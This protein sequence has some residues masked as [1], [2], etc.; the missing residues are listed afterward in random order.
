MIKVNIFTVK[1]TLNSQ[2]LNFPLLVN[3]KLLKEMGIEI[4]F[5]FTV[6]DNYPEGD[7]F[8]VNSKIFL[9]W[10]KDRKEEIFSFFEKIRRKTNRLLWF[11]NTD[12]TGATQFAVLPYVDGYYKGQILKEKENYLKKYYGKRIYTDFYHKKYNII[13]KEDNSGTV[14]PD[15]K[16]LHKIKVYWN[17]SLGDYSSYVNYLY[18]LRCIS[19]LFYF[20]TAEFISS[21]KN[22][23]TDVSCRIGLKYIRNTIKFHRLRIN[24]IL[25]ENFQV[26]TDKI[27]LKEYYSE[28]S[29][30]RI[31]ISPFGAGEFAYRDFEIIINGAMLMKPDMSHL[32]TWPNLY[33]EYKTYV[34]FKWDFSDL[35]DKI[36]EYLAT[37]KYSTIAEEAQNIYHKYLYE[38]QGKEEFCQRFKKIV[39]QNT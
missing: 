26:S 29:N 14:I 36:K 10:W 6:T 2:A 19:N 39:T 34:P 33:Q 38:K 18:R 35:V 23:K 7:T 12:S 16:D 24:E 8:I 22:R 20:R 1:D 30:S 25:K 27:S 32:E 37:E 15:E 4:N 9:N 5:F 3:R 31:G 21:F 17:S 13:D 28:L 11:D